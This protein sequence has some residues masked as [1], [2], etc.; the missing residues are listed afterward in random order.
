MKGI[1]EQLGNDVTFYGIL[2]MN[3]CN[4]YNVKQYIQDFVNGVYFIYSRSYESIMSWK[5]E[6][7]NLF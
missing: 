5:V 7:K 3:K 1:C 2:C 6:Y 4:F